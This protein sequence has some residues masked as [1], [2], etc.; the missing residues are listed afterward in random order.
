MKLVKIS[1][2][3]LEDLNK[4]INAGYVVIIAGEKKKKV[5]WCLAWDVFLSGGSIST[6]F[7]IRW[8]GTLA[9]K[10]Y[11]SKGDNMMTITRN[12][13]LDLIIGLNEMGTTPTG[14]LILALCHAH[15]Q[16]LDDM[17]EADRALE[18]YYV[19]EGRKQA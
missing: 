15:I 5:V 10:R 9:L 2:I 12:A 4:L 7:G 1:K 14:E 18:A 11:W 19:Q 6:V 16:Q 3:K 17:E 8:A 13:V